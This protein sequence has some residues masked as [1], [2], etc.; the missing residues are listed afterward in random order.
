MSHPASC[1]DPDC[2]LSYREHLLTVG[3]AATALPSRAVHR[4]PGQ[5]DEPVTETARRDKAIRADVD[6][7]ARLRRSGERGMPF[8]GAAAHERS[9]GG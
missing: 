7:Y 3:I 2:E 6:S 8:R 9:L 4:T 5:P 1:T